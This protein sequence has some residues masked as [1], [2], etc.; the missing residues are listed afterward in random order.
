VT[1]TGAG[2][3][4]KTRLAVQA[5]AELLDGSGDGVWFVELASI[6]DPEQIPLA[7]ASAIGLQEGLE[8][9]PGG[10]LLKALGPQRSLFVID[11]C[12]HLVDG[13]A[14]LVD[15][16][17]RSCAGV[18]VIATSREPLGVD[19]E[20]VYRVPSMSVPSD[21]VDSFEEAQAFD[22][23]ALFASRAA[24]A[25]AVI[26]DHDVPLVASVCRRLDGIP[27]ALELA[28]ARLASMSLAHLSDRLDQRFRLLT[29]GSRSAMARQQTL[30]ATVE[31][32]YGLLHATERSLLRRLS[33]FVGGFEL[34]AAEQVC[35]G[36][37]VDEFDV[38]NLLHSL[39]E[40]SLV[41]AEQD[42][43]SVRYRLL[44]TIRQYAAAELLREGGDEGVL[45][46]RD[47]HA[48]YVLELAARSSPE[49][50]GAGQ[51][52]VYTRLD[53]EID[54]VRAAL[55]HLSDQRR[56]H[57]ILELVVFLQRFFRSRVFVEVIPKIYAALDDVPDVDDEL[58]GRARLAAGMLSGW[59]QTSIRDEVLRGEA[60]VRRACEI[61]ERTGPASFEALAWGIFAM[62]QQYHQDLEGCASSLCRALELAEAAGDPVVRDEVWDFSLQR[63]PVAALG[64]SVD[65]RL[66]RATSLLESARSRGDLAGVGRA[67]S[68]LAS[69]YLDL[70]AFER[71]IDMYT[72]SIAIQEELGDKHASA[73]RL[74]NLALAHL[75]L[76]RFDEADVAMRRAIRLNRRTGLL[77]PAG[78]MVFVGGCVAVARGEAA[79]GA[80]LLSA[81]DELRRPAYETG[82]LYLTPG[83][84]R[85]QHEAEDAARASLGQ[86]AY[87][88]ER[89]RGRRLS[90]LEAL[91]LALEPSP[92]PAPTAS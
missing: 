11:N 50:E 4:G 12:E 32:S 63:R 92:D 90:V 61:A 89:D 18:H 48:A 44:E 29:G 65:D 31:W 49:L 24:D 72:E 14:K 36:G 51:V 91:A 26:P 47:R 6:S 42:A 21:E 45:E 76:R 79:R 81:A 39:V 87:A 84:V 70:E 16:V 82:Q 56:A 28:A 10:A 74:N 15:A 38:L 23:V 52:A 80:R 67:Y 68:H 20:R 59:L 66:G 5:A 27:L 83:E 88:R 85:A 86:E 37:D 62:F 46:A 41:V 75:Q 25:G 2:G 34:E 19:G 17:M 35:V 69:L 3:A 77:S 7:V 8:V 22:A 53:L 71:A 54:N 33:V 9:D 58:V 43:G 57:E 1:L 40:K 64:L 73:G 78:D 30:Q 55:T 13:V 60:Q